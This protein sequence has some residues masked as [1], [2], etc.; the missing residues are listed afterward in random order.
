MNDPDALRILPLGDR[1]LIV[2]LGDV[3]DPEINARVRVLASRLRGLPGVEEA[4]P[5]LRSVLVIFDPLSTDM[6]M[7]AESV[8]RHA[9]ALPAEPAA[10]PR[11]IEVPVVYGGS[12]GPDLE[13]VAAGHGLTPDQV[14]RAHSEIQYTVYMLGFTPGYPY[15]GILP[16]ALR[17][18]RLPSPRLRVP[19]GSIGIADAMTGIYPLSS[20]GGW[21]LIGRTPLPIYDPFAPDPVLLRPGDRV[22]FVPIPR[23]PFQEAPQA[24]PLRVPERAVLEVR[25]PGLF[26][27]I[28][29]RGRA[30]Y[31]SLGIPPSGA[32]DP[33]AMGMANAAVGNAFDAP[34]LEFTVPGPVLS[35]LDH[36]TIAVSGADLSA[37]VDRRPLERNAAVALRPGQVVEF[38]APRAGV[39]GYLAVAGGFEARRV[40]GSASTFVAGMLGG[41]AGRRLR[42]GDVL[43][44]AGGL[45]GR[46]GRFAGEGAPLPRE[47][48]TVRVIP[49]PQD[50]WLTEEARA[51]FLKDVYR[52]S[53]HS[54]RAGARL[55]GRALAHRS[56]GDFLSD[57]VLPGAIQVPSGGEPI[58]IMPDGPTTGGYPKVAAVISADVR[59]VAQARPGT[60]IRFRA[61]TMDEALDAL[62]REREGY[63]QP[64]DTR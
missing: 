17:T 14:V 22:Q 18:P 42:P 56:G 9:A 35:V 48:V 12:A 8:E 39:W 21:R 20:P 34:A 27:T 32:M 13:E 29:D 45:R 50:E 19:P 15:L 10:A 46:G 51:A 3:L 4:V 44:T 7:V 2:E 33:L 41:S 49:G 11:V 47:D 16:E 23:A 54:D 52:I 57:G 30:G 6:T 59:L 62:R 40:L 28:Q 26:T 60:Q 55:L 31:R 43:G 1:S 58:V 61:V 53:Q 63:G 36:V 24:R 64:A 5:T 25:T 38:G 37:S